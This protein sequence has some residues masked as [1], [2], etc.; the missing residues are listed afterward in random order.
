MALESVNRATI[1]RTTVFGVLYL[2]TLATMVLMLV[3]IV[4]EW[5]TNLTVALWWAALAGMV[6]QHLMVRWD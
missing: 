6:M 4:Q 1:E 2:A 5:P 3:S